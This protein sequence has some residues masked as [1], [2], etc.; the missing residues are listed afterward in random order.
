[1]KRLNR[2][3]ILTLQ[4]NH[5]FLSYNCHYPSRTLSLYV[6]LISF[7]ISVYCSSTNKL[8]F[9]LEIYTCFHD[10]KFL[11]TQAHAFFLYCKSWQNERFFN[12]FQ[13]FR[14]MFTNLNSWLWIV[15]YTHQNIYTIK[16]YLQI[17][18]LTDLCEIKSLL[19]KRF[20]YT[21]LF[22]V[23]SITLDS[24]GGADVV[25]L[26]NDLVIINLSH[27]LLCTDNLQHQ[28]L[29]FSSKGELYSCFDKASYLKVL[30]MGDEILEPGTIIKPP[31]KLEEASIL[32]KNVYGITASGLKE[33]VRLD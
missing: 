15:F 24:N 8:F 20:F 17:S 2:F 18:I 32:I 6:N 31:L 29:S 14:S 4:S 26:K 27:S 9:Y 16:D 19:V 13:L 3:K 28:S 10:W 1:V 23:S 11:F 5:L 33:Y 25:P 12:T 30:N 7:L 22:V 21:L